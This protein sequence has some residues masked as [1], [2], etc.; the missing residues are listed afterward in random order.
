M[1]TGKRIA[2]LLLIFV[3]FCCTGLQAYAATESQDGL[4]VTLTTDKQS[5]LPGEAINVSLLLTNGNS[6][7]I[8]SV[9]AQVSAPDGYILAA[10]YDFQTPVSS[11]LT[12]N[13]VWSH[14]VGEDDSI[15]ILS[16]ERISFDETAQIYYVN[17]MIYAF[18]KP[19]LSQIDKEEISRSVNGMIE[20]E[21]SGALNI[22]QIQ[23][24][25]NSIENLERLAS[26]LEGNPN[27]T[28]ATYD[29]PMK[30]EN[31]LVLRYFDVYEVALHGF[32]LPYI[33][34]TIVV[35]GIC[36]AAALKQWKRREL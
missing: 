6:F 27:V 3:L 7:P 8:S 28:Y 12:L 17:N 24:K 1:N 18:I 33:F 29:I 21:I 2:A 32:H 11:N 25:E 14:D 34:L 9:H 36:V 4:S 23:V 31:I 13:A 20:A 15:Y 30:E 5:Y 26:T 22:L 10:G 16:D 19:S 35:A